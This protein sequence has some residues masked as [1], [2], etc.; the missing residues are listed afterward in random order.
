MSSYNLFYNLIYNTP[1]IPDSVTNDESGDFGM[2]ICSSPDNGNG[3]EYQIWATGFDCLDADHNRV[4]DIVK[5]KPQE[6]QDGLAERTYGRFI[7]KGWEPIR[8]I[9]YGSSI[10]PITIRPT[11]LSDHSKEACDTPPQSVV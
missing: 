8:G 10:P 9:N 1:E 3:I 2:S 5:D 11:D 7:E 6:W 4:L